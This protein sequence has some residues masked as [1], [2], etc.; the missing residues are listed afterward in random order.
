MSPIDLL[1]RLA[2]VLEHHDLAYLITGSM[3]STI[4]GEARFTNDI[5]VI[6]DLPESK[7]TDFCNSFPSDEFYVSV[8]AAVEAVRARRMFN[9]IHNASGLK[10]N[11]M[12]ASSSPY[13]CSRLQRGRSLPILTDRSVSYASPEDVILKKMEFYQAGSSEKHLRDIAGML[14]FQGKSIDTAYLEGWSKSLG[15]DAIW[16]EIRDRIRQNESGQTTD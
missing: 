14:K 15:L 7:V 1:L 4:Y 3:A 9:V 6:I 2:I 16:L 12:V 5:D 8:P 10:I 13:D 11:V